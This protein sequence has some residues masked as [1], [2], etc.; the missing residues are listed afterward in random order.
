MRNKFIFCTMVLIAFC[1][2]SCK[3][4]KVPSTAQQT[5]SQQQVVDTKVTSVLEVEDTLNLGTLHRSNTT[6]VVH[7]SCKC[8][9]TTDIRINSI[10]TTAQNI[11]I[12][13]SPRITAGAKGTILCLIE[14]SRQSSGIHEET[15]YIKTNSTVKPDVSAILKYTIE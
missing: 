6:S 14:T 8:N 11:Q 10:T 5:T 12:S 7:L 9:G 2:I 4:T 13:S 3:T 1:I 15:I